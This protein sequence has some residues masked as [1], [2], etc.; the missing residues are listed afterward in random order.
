MLDEVSG[1]T[2]TVLALR[3]GNIVLREEQEPTTQL[4]STSSREQSAA[5]TSCSLSDLGHLC[6]KREEEA[7]Q[8]SSKGNLLGLLQLKQLL[9]R[10]HR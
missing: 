3:S 2:L 6:T 9:H 4:R 10:L 5:W 7:G 1:S 8:N